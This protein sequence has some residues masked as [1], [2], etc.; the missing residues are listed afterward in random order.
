MKFNRISWVLS[1]FI[2]VLTIGSGFAQKQEIR[3]LKSFS[4]VSVSDRII[5]LLQ[6]DTISQVIL[7]PRGD[8]WNEEIKTHVDGKDLSIR[9][10]GRF[11]EAA[12]FCYVHYTQPIVNLSARYGGIIRTDSLVVL[13]TK[14]L[15]INATIDG[16]TNLD[17]SVDELIIDAGAGSDIYV[18]GKAG[19][20]TVHATS[21]AKIH[22]D[23]LECEDAE[24]NCSLGAKVWL[25]AKNNYKATAGSGGKIYY[26]AEPSGT[27]DRNRIT[28]G[29]VE[30]LPR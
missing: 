28:G 30:L 2:W 23:D 18:K 15:E 8:A 10:D 22:L 25:T 14:K 6:P 13:Q 20:V 24:V 17:V 26:Y 4:K 7:N 3:P 5:V 12:I 11:R 9:S 21:G 27:F 19:K 29:N 1:L 16:F